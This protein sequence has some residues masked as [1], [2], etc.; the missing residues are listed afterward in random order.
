MAKAFAISGETYPLRRELRA[1]GC[2]WNHDE[3]AYLVDAARAAG[4][5]SIAQAH[6]LDVC[7]IEADPDDL[8]PATGEKLRAIRQARRDRYAERL[9]SQAETQARIAAKE[10][11]KHEPYTSDYSFITQP[12]LVGHHSERRHRNLLARLCK[13]MDNEMR[14]LIKSDKLREKADYIEQV[15]A[16]IKGDA[17]RARQKARER[18]DAIISKGDLVETSLGRGVVVAVNSKTFTIN[19]EDRGFTSREDKSWVR[20][21]E[22][23]EPKPMTYRFNVGD[24]VVAR[25]LS[26]RYEGIVKR[27][28]VR[29]YIVEYQSYGKTYRERFS[30]SDVHASTEEAIA[31]QRSEG[32]K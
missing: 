24:K 5:L 23:R 12:I 3:K 31:G 26:A 29:G 4:A 11:A 15:G 28:T 18:A 14:A 10:R 9:R 27:R 25:R 30:P 20:L 2:I 21:I 17:E 19:F 13:N 8:V 16:T 1:V 7:E 6:G 22:K 32:L